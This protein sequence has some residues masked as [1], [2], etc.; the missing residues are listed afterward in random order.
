MG[1]DP[2]VAYTF[3]NHA[4]LDESGKQNHGFVELPAADRWVDAPVPELATAIRYDAQEARITVAPNP[5][6]A[7]WQG[8]RV[9]VLFR[10]DPFDRR[11]NLVEGDRSFAFFVEPDGR[12]KGTIYDGSRWYGVESTPGTIRAGR[13]YTAEYRYDPASSLL[14][15]LNGQLLNIE[16]TQGDPVR[17]VGPVGIKI[18]YWPGGDSRYT[19]LGLMGPVFIYTLDPQR[20]VLD[21]FGKLV[22]PGIGADRDIFNI[23]LD[24]V[25][26]ELTPVERDKAVHAG[27]LM[28]EGAKRTIGAALG[29][30]TDTR[31]TLQDL[32]QLS[33][34]A[35]DMIVRNH[36]SGTNFLEDPEY[37]DILHDARRVIDDASPV[38]R[39]TFLAQV[40]RLVAAQPLT[41][42]RSREILERYPELGKCFGTITG[43]E[44]GA[45]AD[46]PF[47][48]WIDDCVRICQDGTGAGG[49]DAGPAGGSRGPGDGRDPGD[50]EGDPCSKDFHIH[51]HCCCKDQEEES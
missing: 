51:V 31:Q 6:L 35:D 50:R 38:A 37:R 46:N 15:H 36:Q 21:R 8:F 43:G 32:A 7:G 27:R 18:G 11:I 33:Q 42:D 25:R 5:T 44:P 26:N 41:A 30:S 28:V 34:R 17:P 48:G 9:R 2:V 13:W 16:P 47:D 40:V 10:P 49:P 3:E 45:P 19:F 39:D 24:V 22:C 14:L 12:L 1:W 23:L 20:E 4:A 29:T